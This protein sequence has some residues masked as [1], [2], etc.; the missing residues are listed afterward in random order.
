M[1]LGVVRVEAIRPSGKVV[2]INVMMDES[3]DSTLVR[4]G[5]ARRSGF[6]GAARNLDVVGVGAVC[7]R[8]QS[9]QVKLQLLTVTGDIVMIEGSTIPTVT[10]PVA[11][12][13]WPKL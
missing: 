6:S 3:S 11:V 8:V 9:H 5:L 4:E 12:V 1:A 7:S 10:R 2:G 13:D